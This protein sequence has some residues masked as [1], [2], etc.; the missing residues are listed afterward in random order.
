M[1]APASMQQK[2]TQQ[3]IKDERGEARKDQPLLGVRR[4]ETGRG[5]VEVEV[6]GRCRQEDRQRCAGVVNSRDVSAG[7]TCTVGEVVVCV[8]GC[9]RG[10]GREA[11]RCVCVQKR[12]MQ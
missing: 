9:E 6:G 12:A 7:E 11:T 3:T 10:R 5:S 2:E 1:F 8:V 4:G